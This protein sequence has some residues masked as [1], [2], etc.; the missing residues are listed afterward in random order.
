MWFFSSLHRLSLFK[1]L[2]KFNKYTCFVHFVGNKDIFW[3]SSSWNLQTWLYWCIIHI[4]SWEKA[5]NGS[6]SSHSWMEEVFR[7]WSQWWSCSRW[8]WWWS[9]RSWFAGMDNSQIEFLMLLNC[10]IATFPL[11]TKLNITDN[12]IL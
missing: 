8:W 9:T 6:L 2:L 1:M 10:L 11:F 12:F 5:W 7:I 4:L 3:S